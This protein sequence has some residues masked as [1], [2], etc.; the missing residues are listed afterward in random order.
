MYFLTEQSEQGVEQAA[1]Q[2]SERR[3]ALVGV[4]VREYLGSFT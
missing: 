4:R 2:G 1:S 3:N